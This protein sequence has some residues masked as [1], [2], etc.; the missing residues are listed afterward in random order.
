MCKEAKRTSLW[1]FICWLFHIIKALFF[2]FYC[3]LLI[4]FEVPSNGGNSVSL[5]HLEL[6]WAMVSFISFILSINE[7]SRPLTCGLY[8][9][10]PPYSNPEPHPS[11]P[12]DGGSLPSW[13]SKVK[14]RV[15]QSTLCDPMDY[16]VHGIFQARILEWVAFPFSSGSSQPRDQSQVSHIACG[17]FTSWA[18]REAWLLV[19]P[20]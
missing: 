6:S 4:A 18:T 17:F 13:L 5:E 10:L 15:T 19:N 16:T 12:A 20:H 14:V 8:R 7:S 9:T 1:G 11:S 3:F 2:Y